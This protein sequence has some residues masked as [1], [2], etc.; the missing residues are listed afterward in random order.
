MLLILIS[1]SLSVRGQPGVFGIM[2]VFVHTYQTKIKQNS[3]EINLNIFIK[4]LCGLDK[5]TKNK[6]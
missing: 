5:I 6:S 3:P 4:L 2:R 1:D